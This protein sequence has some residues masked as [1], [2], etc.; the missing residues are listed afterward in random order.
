MKLKIDNI[1]E[2]AIGFLLASVAL[3]VLN[4]LFLDSMI[5]KIE[6]SKNK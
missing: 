4:V 2:I 1:A 3:R 6:A 5:D